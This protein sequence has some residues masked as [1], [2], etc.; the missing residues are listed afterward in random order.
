M[1]NFAVF[2]DVD[3]VLNTRN[4][5]IASPDGHTGVDPKRIEILS[6]VLKK[7]YPD[8]LI[9]L[10]SDW[11]DIKIGDDLEYLKKELAKYELTISGYTKHTY[12]NRGQGIIDYLKEHS[13]IED[14]VVLDDN[15]FDFEDFPQLWERLLLTDG[16][17]EAKFA[18]NTPS[19]ESMVFC[20]AIKE[21]S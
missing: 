18:S 3:G 17:Q 5:P 1:S 2:L 4:T 20:D 9:I 14:Y 7:Y 21:F 11:K 16:I 8:G 12:R 19:V 13:E 6:K 15:L 10:T